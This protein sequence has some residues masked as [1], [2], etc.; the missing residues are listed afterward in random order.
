[1]TLNDPIHPSIHFFLAKYKHNENNNTTDNANQDFKVTPLFD[2]DYIRNGTRYRHS[3][4][5]IMIYLVIFT[6]AVLKGVISND[7]E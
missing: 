5:A 7:L 2:A 4:N 3:H 1:M 6:H